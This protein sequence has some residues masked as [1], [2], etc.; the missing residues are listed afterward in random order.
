MRAI[1]AVAAAD[2][3]SACFFVDHFPGSRWTFV[4]LAQLLQQWLQFLLLLFVAA[5]VVAA[6]AFLPLLLG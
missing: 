5:D 1:V 3:A 6:S 2:A 4:N